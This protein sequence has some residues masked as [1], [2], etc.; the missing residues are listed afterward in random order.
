MVTRRPT[1][2]ARHTPPTSLT[3]L[4]SPASYRGPF[5]IPMALTAGVPT[6]SELVQAY[7]MLAAVSLP[8]T[9]E[10]R[11]RLVMRAIAGLREYRRVSR[12]R[13]KV[14]AVSVKGRQDLMQMILDDGWGG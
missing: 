13:A 1:R 3:T 9:K 2:P 5:A 11:R 6:A 4:P 14:D 10:E 7:Y 12:K 8:F